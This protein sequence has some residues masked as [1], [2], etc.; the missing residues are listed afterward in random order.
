[1][2]KKMITL[3]LTVFVLTVTFNIYAKQHDSTPSI[4]RT[5][6]EV[7]QQFKS[8][9]SGKNADYIPELAKVNP[10]YFGIAIVTVEGK[11]FSIGDTNI[12]FAIESISKPFTYALALEDNGEQLITRKVGLNATGH[13]FNSVAAIEE[14]PDHLQNPLVNAGAIQIT[15]YIKG[16]D[17]KNKWERVLGLM[18]QSSDGQVYLGNAVY[19]SEMA[20]NQHNEAIAL[21]LQSYNMLPG[22]PF[23]AV[24][25]YT[26]ACSVM[27]T[28]HQL[29]IMGA[30][31]ANS[32]INPITHKKVISPQNV[33]DTLSEMVVNGL[34]EDSGAWWW[35]IGIP[36]KSGVGGGILAVIPHKMAIVV[37]SPPLDVSGNSVR[38]QAV[39]ETLSHKWKLHLLN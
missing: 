13:L 34:Y 24:D 2:S 26:K 14:K 9:K 5:L 23:D 36:A 30:T 22:D 32:G 8:L 33:R 27:V 35:K 6:K 10:D 31:L 1:M 37:F 38:G 15:Q 11:F 7:Y 20:T 21:L 28:A 17:S 4:E 19:Q 18:Q 12:P 3:L 16:S 29:A 39:I 25:R